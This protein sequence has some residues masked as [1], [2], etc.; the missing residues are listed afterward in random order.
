MPELADWVENIGQGLG[1]RIAQYRWAMQV[2]REVDAARR[3]VPGATLTTTGHS[4][5]GGLASAAS[6]VTGASG[7][8]F[9]AAGLHENSL[10]VYFEN[11]PA[12]LAVA[13]ARYQ[14]PQGLVTAYTVDWDFLSNFQDRLRLVVNP[15]LGDR[16]ELDGP[17]DFATET[18]QAIDAAFSA[19]GAVPGGALVKLGINLAAK[20]GTGYLMYRCHSMDVVLYGLLVKENLISDNRDLLGYPLS[21][22]F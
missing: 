12:E 3:Q 20:A 14:K 18:I 11:D 16:K 15:A 17:H 13:L 9:N 6:V 22:F 4:L 8:T 1:W 21:R 7:V 19:A 2:A 10:R 5:G